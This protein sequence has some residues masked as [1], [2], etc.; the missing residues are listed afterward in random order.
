MARLDGPERELRLLVDHREY[1]VAERTR[2]I[3]RLR[4]HLHELDPAGSRRPGALDRPTHP[5][6]RLAAAL[7]DQPG[8]RRP[9]R[10]RARSS[11]APNSPWR[12]TTLETE[13][14]ELRRAA[15]AR[16]ARDLPGC[17]ALPRPRSSAR[18]PASTGSNPAT[19]TPATTA[20]HRYRSGRR[21]RPGTG[22]AAPATASSTPPCT[23]SRSPK[24]AGTRPR[25][26]LIAR[27]QSRRQQRT[28]SA[29]RTQTPPLRRR[30]PSAPPDDRN[31]SSPLAA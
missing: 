28:R 11:A 29:P 6:R 18:P 7:D 9:A 1:L 3:S 24:P 15:G 10:P 5:R 16:A 13:I 26:P 4:W 17:G 12:S 19:P 8:T 23:A 31:S 22:S 21:T 25:K 14:A 2:V 30:L 20:P 27:R